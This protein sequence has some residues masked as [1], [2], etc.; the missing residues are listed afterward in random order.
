MKSK[1]FKTVNNTS[2][3]QMCDTMCAIRIQLVLLMIDCCV[4]Y[5]VAI[6][7]LTTYHILLTTFLVGLVLLV[8]VFISC[9]LVLGRFGKVVIKYL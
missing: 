8:S 6:Y 3:A 2:Y 7:F 9:R 4:S 5:L 1:L